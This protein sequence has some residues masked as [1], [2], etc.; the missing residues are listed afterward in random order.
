[1]NSLID[2]ELPSYTNSNTDK[3]DDNLAHDLIL[4]LEPNIASDITDTVRAE[5]N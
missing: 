3:L 1:V 5:P 4:I 2:K